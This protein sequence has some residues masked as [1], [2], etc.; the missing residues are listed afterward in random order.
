MYEDKPKITNKISIEANSSTP[1]KPA[2]LIRYACTKT[3][4]IVLMN[5]FLLIENKSL[6]D[7]RLSIFDN[8]IMLKL[9]CLKE[10]KKIIIDNNRPEY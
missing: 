5:K 6:K 9:Y 8:L 2:F 1:I 4:S 7:L 10:F 3:R